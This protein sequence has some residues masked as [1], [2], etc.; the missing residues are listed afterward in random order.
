MEGIL[1][2]IG[3]AL[4]WGVSS[5]VMARPARVLGMWPT[6]AAVMLVGLV[7]S[8]PAALIVHGAPGGSTGAWLWAGV[9]SASFVGGSALWLLGV[10]R[11]AI[12]IVT[13]LV[14]TDGA[15]GATFAIIGGERPGT[16]ALLALGVIVCGVVLVAL[17][18]GRGVLSAVDATAARQAALLGLGAGVVFGAVFYASGE[19]AALG[20][21][22]AVAA[23]RAGGVALVSLPVL[24]RGGHAIPR[25]MW[26]WLAG[27]GLIDT[28]GYML[29][30]AGTANG[31]AI[32]SV[33]AS[34]YAVVSVTGG[35]V[36]F[37]ERVVPRQ[38]IGIALT[39]SG[40]AALAVVRAV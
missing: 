26:P 10:R 31:V 11:G 32:T 1:L 37:R 2:G 35:I 38:L 14:A 24:A 17:G 34:Q 18:P 5:L 16:L 22:W 13:A 36:L 40:V 8:L 4:C 28:V 29:V 6:L 20:A 25:A 33:L 19:T 7:A 12:S 27:G 23:V 39:I 9:A 3:G 15:I 21:L 30:V